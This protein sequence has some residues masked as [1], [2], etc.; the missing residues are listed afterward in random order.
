MKKEML[1][2][3]A[4]TLVFIGLVSL[5][6]CR[7]DKEEDL[8]DS[9]SLSNESISSMAEKS[10]S[11]E[12]DGMTLKSGTDGCGSNW[13]IATCAIVTEDS[14]TYPK[15]I[16]VDYGDGCIDLHGRTKSGK[17]FI[18]LT[19]EL[20]NT[21]A[22]RTVTFDNYKI[23]G[24]QIAGTRITTNTGTNA[25]GQ[26]V[27]H[28]VVDV[29]FTYEGASYQRDFD[30]IITWISGWDTPECNDNSISISGSGSITRPSGVV[31]PRVILTPL[32]LQ[33]GCGYI[34]SGVLQIQAPLGT[35]SINYG[36][37]SCDDQ[38]SF[39]RPNGEVESFTL[40][41]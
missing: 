11:D 1:K 22:I 27:F 25:S 31:V 14:D 24:V 12:E 37:G 38:A 17:I 33:S 39:T 18:H 26:P 40:H 8:F 10:I 15:T 29:T 9:D 16:T 2:W 28:R 20:I 34:T 19:D 6:A 35:F 32:T 7:K 36:D 4:F 41:H 23:N 5:S 30:E 13:P 21:N 3:T